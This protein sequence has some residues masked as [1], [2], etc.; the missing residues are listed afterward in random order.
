MKV[1]GLSCFPRSA[2]ATVSHC[3]CA[4]ALL[5][6]AKIVFG[7]AATAVRLLA[8]ACARALRIR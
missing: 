4:S 6:W 7:I 5:S 2:S 8:G 1:P 3:A